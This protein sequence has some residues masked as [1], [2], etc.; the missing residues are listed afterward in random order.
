MVLTGLISV[1]ISLNVIVMYTWNNAG[2]L[3]NQDLK[4]L[5]YLFKIFS[6]CK[7]LNCFRMRFFET[8]ADMQSVF[9]CFA[10]TNIN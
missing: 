1:R 9:T 5:L 10:V 3:P 4:G 2:I 7:N 6:E 8:C